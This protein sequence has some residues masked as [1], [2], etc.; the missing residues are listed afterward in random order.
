MNKK[1]RRLFPAYA[2]FPVSLVILINFLTFYGTRLISSGFT[3]YDLALSLDGRLPFVPFFIFFYILA[4]IQWVAS[5]IFIARE[6]Q[7]FCYR[8]VAADLIAKLCCAVIFLVLPTSMARPEVTGTDIWSRLVSL[9]Y[10]LD[11]P[12]NL[13]PSIHVVESWLCLRAAFRMKK[14]GRWYR[15]VSLVV[16]LLVFLSVL[17][18]KQHLVLDVAGGILVMEIGLFLAEKLR[19]ERFFERLQSRFFKKSAGAEEAL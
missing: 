3:H 10:A 5:Y 1:Q 2:L 8:T 15:P 14:P 6:G 16:T 9:I 19:A 12:D 11:T 4:Y 13:F 7:T 18:V 17:L